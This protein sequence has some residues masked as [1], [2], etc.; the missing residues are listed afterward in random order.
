VA[1]ATA[2][3]LPL[4]GTA[5]AYGSLDWSVPAAPTL[6]A[7]NTFFA[8]S[9]M[10]QTFVP[11]RTGQ[12]DHIALYVGSAD[13]VTLPNFQVQIWTVNTTTTATLAAVA[14]SSTSTFRLQKALRDWEGFDLSGP[15]SVRSGTQYALVVT[16]AAPVKL[17]WYY[18]SGYGYTQGMMWL[19]PSW[20]SASTLDFAFQD[21]ITDGSAVN[22]PPTLSQPANVH[23]PEGTA[24]I[25]SGTFSDPDAGD[26]VHLSASP[27]SLTWTGTNVG[28]WT[29]TG[30][31]ADEDAPV[32]TVTITAG[33][34]HNPAVTT[35][36]TVTFYGV[37]PSVTVSPAGS[38]GPAMAAAT[39]VNEGTPLAFTGAARTPVVADAASLTYAWSVTKDGAPYATA[40]SATSSFNFTPDD[41]GAY[42]ITM[43]ATDDGAE[44]GS[45][46][47]AVTVGDV[48]PTAIITGYVP[49][50]TAPKIVLPYEWVTFNGT[51][52][53]PGMA[54]PHTASWDFGD[55][56]P[57]ASGW[58]ATHYFTAP[59]F[60][61]VTLTVAQGD[62][63]GVGTAHVTVQVM[64]PSDALTA[65]AAYVQQL[66]GLN[67]G[68]RQSLATKLDNAAAAAGRGNLTAAT[69]E[70]NA[71]LNELQAY[72]NTGK[73][74]ETYATQLQD[75]IRA[76]KGAL[77]SYNRLLDFWPLGL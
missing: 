62:D 66:P 69:N 40:G 3:M 45:G 38:A 71:F 73:V 16:T 31:A 46:S 35:T 5:H 39:S 32:E 26:T 14:T 24:P 9:A 59:G 61:T 8:R 6:P 52:T 41:E 7:A 29:W 11:Q 33:D 42:V 65:I 23:M 60:Y 49:T 30:A 28:R 43:T 53:D 47:F 76:V 10:A 56:T 74:S 13:G 67:P 20:G 37:A 34:G 17:N 48:L 57:A 54:D 19:G 1:S 44:T 27:G 12:L 68:Q 25:N 64:A 55:S 21:Y 18:M 15:V 63:P 36:F 50:L 4:A 70:M 22:S 58:T 2:L 77:G 72:V 75:D 51:F